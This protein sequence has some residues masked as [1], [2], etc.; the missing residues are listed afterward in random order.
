M[1]APGPDE[2]TIF[3]ERSERLKE[4]LELSDKFRKS[5]EKDQE[6]WG[7]QR[8]RL[9]IDTS[10]KRLE[11]H[12]LRAM[13]SDQLKADTYAVCSRLLSEGFDVIPVNDLS[14][15]AIEAPGDNPAINLIWEG[16]FG[17][18]FS[19]S[20][21]ISGLMKGSFSA[22]L[23]KRIII[24][25]MSWNSFEKFFA[26]SDANE[27]EVGALPA[28][29]A[30][31]TRIGLLFLGVAM[32]ISVAFP[33]LTSSGG[34]SAS[35]SAAVVGDISLASTVAG[36]ILI[37]AGLISTGYPLRRKVY[38]FIIGLMVVYLASII[39]LLFQPVDTSASTV[40]AFGTAYYVATVTFCFLILLMFTDFRKSFILYAAAGTSF[41]Y[42]LLMG[43]SAYFQIAGST[44]S[45]LNYSG[46]FPGYN[47]FF[48]FSLHFLDYYP[49]SSGS[50]LSTLL[51][52]ASAILFSAFS[53][54]S[55]YDFDYSGEKKEAEEETAG[56]ATV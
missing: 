37:V 15:E 45:L 43:L 31:N 18:Q 21:F 46:V 39:Y 54:W 33:F 23:K 8:S 5:I 51:F 3:E 40:I 11:L 12:V 16:K 38:V 1:S 4:Y 50:S 44:L 56:A 47:L 20:K 32:L 19:S 49:V 25:A 10:G 48:S 13:D 36:L 42:A 29:M 24:I 30:L 7:S 41:A 26:K 17:K 9:D 35:G 6:K 52:V 27:V 55:A 28:S 14:P 53:F 2:K 22:K 34:N